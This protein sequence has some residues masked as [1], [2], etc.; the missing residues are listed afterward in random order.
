MIH[1]FWPVS[2]QPSPSGVARVFMD[3]VSLPASRSDRPYENI[4]SPLATGGR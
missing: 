2:T 3:A 4:A 1:D